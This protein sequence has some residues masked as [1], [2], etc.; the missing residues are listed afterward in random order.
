M[1]LGRE[2]H[3]LFI[4]MGMEP[5]RGQKM[6]PNGPLSLAS[7]VRMLQVGFDM[8][9]QTPDLGTFFC[10]GHLLIGIGRAGQQEKCALWNEPS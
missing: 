7:E 8:I 6:L 3:E 4:L 1:G 10:M 2:C 5:V 9:C